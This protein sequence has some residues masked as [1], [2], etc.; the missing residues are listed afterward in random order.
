MFEQAV[1]GKYRWSYKGSLSVEDLW[2]L[3]LRQLDEIFK[4]LSREVRAASEE[5]LLD[6]ESEEDKVLRNKIA[7]VRHIV[8]VKLTERDAARA[9][10]ANREQKEKLLGILAEKQEAQLRDLSPEALQEMIANL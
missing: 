4:A 9:A 5:S 7:I 3:S 2:D 8:S 6:T 10:V 1:R